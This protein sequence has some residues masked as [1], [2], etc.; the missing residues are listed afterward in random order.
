MR[1]EPA[2]Q[3]VGIVRVN[4]HARRIAVQGVPQFSGTVSLAPP[5]FDPRFDQHD[6]PG[7]RQTQQLHGQQGAAQATA[8]NQH[9]G[10][11]DGRRCLSAL[12][13]TH[14]YSLF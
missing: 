5:Q 6:I 1:F 13:L 11:A 12:W 8:N 14:G 4:A 7:T 10:L 2:R 9:I 3:I